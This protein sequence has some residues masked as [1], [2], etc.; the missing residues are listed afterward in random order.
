LD[1]DNGATDYTTKQANKANLAIKVL[2]LG[3]EFHMLGKREIENYYH[4]EAIKRLFPGIVF[5]AD[6]EISDYND[7]Q[8][9]IKD[10]ILA[11]QNINFKTKNNMMIFNEMTTSEWEE[12]GFSISA[13][14]KDIQVIISKMIE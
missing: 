13:T 1:S 6:F 14:K 9:D 4:I 10:K 5:P 11:H 7:V 8:K 12:V 3:G 2:N